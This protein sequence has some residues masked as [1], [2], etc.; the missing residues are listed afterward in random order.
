MGSMG[1]AVGEKVTNAVE[2]ADK[3]HLPLII[4]TASGVRVCRRVFYL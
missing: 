2:Y 4:F 3:K 1:M